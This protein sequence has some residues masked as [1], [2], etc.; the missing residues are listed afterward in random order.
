MDECGSDVIPEAEAQQVRRARAQLS[1]LESVRSFATAGRAVFTLVSKRTGDRR[2]FRVRRAEPQPGRA[3]QDFWFIDMLTGPDN[4]HDYTYLGFW[5]AAND[6]S[7]VYG[8]NKKGFGK[9]A[10]DL[11]RWLTQQ[12]NNIRPEVALRFFEQ[13]EFWHEGRCGR[14]GRA[15]TDPTSIAAGIGPVCGTMEE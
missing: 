15:L 13:C 2:T 5:R 3:V 6:G 14:C 9:Q 1:D 7:L 4:T 12:L 10:G 8:H 11:A